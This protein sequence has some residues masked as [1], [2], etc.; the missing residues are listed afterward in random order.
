M[1][2]FIAATF[3]TFASSAHAQ[4]SPANNSTAVAISA[5]AFA[6]RFEKSSPRV[7]EIE[8][9]IGGREA[10]VTRASLLPNPT[11]SLGREE[12]FPDGGGV[13]ENS[14]TLGW[15]L[16]V[17]GRRSRQTRSARAQVRAERARGGR[18][19][20]AALSAA[21]ALYYDAAF[22]RRRS[23]ALAEGRVPLARMVL[24][25]KARVKEGDAATYDLSRLELELAAYD[26]QLTEVQV[27]LDAARR[28]LGGLLGEPN[29]L[30]EASDDLTVRQVAG[31]TSEA[32][33]ALASRGDY[34]ATMLE[35]TA[36]DAALSAASRG[37]VPRL[38]FD[39]GLKTADLGTGSATGYTA[40]L[41]VELPLF[42]HG[43]ADAKSARAAKRTATA[44][45]Q[46][47]E[48]QVPV[49]V[50]IA[51]DRL[52]SRNKAAGIFRTAQLERSVAL[53][54]KAESI[55]QSGDGS[56]VELLDAYRAASGARLRYLTLLRRAKAAQ[57]DLSQV[58]GQRPKFVAP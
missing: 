58:L 46:L 42:S 53:V 47:L 2:A 23:D 43:Q 45:R 32:A 52:A 49:E 57:L 30:Y 51:Q 37:W 24:A 3:A 10:D 18:D 56:V 12:V 39:V 33:G 29:V 55:Y 5:Q 50:H 26:E 40:M 7:A 6:E 21:L 8:S 28:G 19:K 17:S 4:E 35:Q 41:S 11:L 22:A 38:G 44:R 15:S 13:A 20:L 48:Q 16:D 34:A 36:A 27:A 25:L 9:R 31:Q 14:V 54:A 1:A